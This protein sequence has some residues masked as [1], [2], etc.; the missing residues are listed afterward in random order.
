MTE[1][2]KTEKKK[3]RIEDFKETLEE[4]EEMKK[5]LTDEDGKFNQVKFMAYMATQGTNGL[6]PITLM[7]LMGSDKKSDKK[8]QTFNEIAKNM[9]DLRISLITETSKALKEA[10]HEA[11]MEDIIKIVNET[12]RETQVCVGNLVMMDKNQSKII[13]LMIYSNRIKLL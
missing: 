11:S 8:E 1:E 12:I 7:M 10:G 4:I 13:T 6:N 9:N 5:L 2:E 3:K